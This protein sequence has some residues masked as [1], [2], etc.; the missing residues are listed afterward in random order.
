M[1]GIVKLQQHEKKIVTL[2]ICK[3]VPVVYLQQNPHSLCPLTKFSAALK[4]QI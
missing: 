3:E 2:G 4:A 1:A